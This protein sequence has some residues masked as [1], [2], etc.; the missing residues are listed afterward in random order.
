MASSFSLTSLTS[1]TQGDRLIYIA[2]ILVA[3]SLLHIFDAA[4]AA[5][6]FG[7]LEILG[8]FLLIGYYL[9]NQIAVTYPHEKIWKKRMEASVCGVIGVFSALLLLAPLLTWQYVTLHFHGDRTRLFKPVMI[10]IL[11]LW[12]GTGIFFYSAIRISMDH[13]AATQSS[14]PPQQGPTQ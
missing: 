6:Q 8:S 9:W 1:L 3:T 13:A 5:H 11:T 12:I 7:Q 14:L 10:A 2:P 4:P